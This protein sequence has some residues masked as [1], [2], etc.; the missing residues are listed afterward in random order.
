MWSPCKERYHEAIVGEGG[1]QE[2]ICWFEKHCGRNINVAKP[3]I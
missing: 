2:L 3:K 1:G